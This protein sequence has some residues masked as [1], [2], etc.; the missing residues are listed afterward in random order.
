MDGE[1]LEDV[2][3][4]LGRLTWAAMALE[5]VV[6]SVCRIVKP[7]HGPYDD[8]PIGARVDEAVKDLAGY[9]DEAL[10]TRAR[11]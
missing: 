11:G 7:R 6:Y 5:E 2:L 3:L 8:H 9:D 10:Q 4:E 1:P